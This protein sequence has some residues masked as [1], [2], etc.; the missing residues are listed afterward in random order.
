M[1]VILYSLAAMITY[2][3]RFLVFLIVCSC[4][5]FSAARVKLSEIRYVLVFIA[6]LM[7]VNTLVVYL[8][9]PEEGVRIYGTRH[10]IFKI[11]GR[12]TIT[13]EQLFYMLNLV[14]KYFSVMP[15]ALIFVTTTEP[16]EFASSLNM[17]GVSYRVAYAVALALRY[18]PDIQ[19]SFFEI[20]QAQQARGIDMSRKAGLVTRVKNVSAILFP[21]I[22][23]SLGRIQT[24]SNAMELRGFG[25]N[26]RR[27]WY[28]AR[29]FKA[30]DFAA[31]AIPAVLVSAAL[32][33]NFVNGGRFYNPFLI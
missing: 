2:D 19:R 17:V 16:S 25:K 32:W 4:A 8:F 13:L 5:V 30:R 9:S 33:L 28:R 24:I 20:S 11:A 21:L 14:L 15:M 29:P 1:M 10:E 3:T 7:A 23:T 31:A 6:A 22:F 18:I 27:T 12:Y 26:N